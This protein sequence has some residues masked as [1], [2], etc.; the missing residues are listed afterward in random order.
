VGWT[1]L[2]HMNR[3]NQERPPGLETRAG[4][5]IRHRESRIGR[6]ARQPAIGD[7]VVGRSVL[8]VPQNRTAGV[9][10]LRPQLLL[11]AQELVVLGEAVGP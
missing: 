1:P 11:D 3:Q 6:A 8:S 4:A 9:S 5:F 7:H 2:H 10:G